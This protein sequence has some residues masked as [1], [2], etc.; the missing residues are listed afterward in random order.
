MHVGTHID[1]PLHF[2]RD[3]RKISDF[4]P[5]K[6]VGRGVLVD[7]RNKKEIGPEVLENIQKNDIVLFR[8]DWS[9]HF[10][11]P[12]YFTDYPTLTESCAQKLVALDVSMIGVDFPSPDRAP[13]PLHPTL[14]SAEILIIENMTNLAQLEGKA[15]DLLAIPPKIEADGAI[16]RVV[17]RID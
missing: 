4:P 1:A 17:A 9:E 13:W 14:L 6:F 10:F 7:A 15:F 3:G 16:V 5:E 8:T 11:K 2:I 12:E